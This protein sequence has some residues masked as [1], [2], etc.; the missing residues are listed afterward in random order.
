MKRGGYFFVME[1]DVKKHKILKRQALKKLTETKQR[2]STS[3]GKMNNKKMKMSWDFL[4][5]WTF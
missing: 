3:T 5:L 4:F 1:N 2:K